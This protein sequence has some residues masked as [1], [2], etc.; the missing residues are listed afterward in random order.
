[1]KERELFNLFNDNPNLITHCPVCNLR[2]NPLEA[3]VLQE[4]EGGHLVYIKCR[5]CQG[6]IL[7]VISANALGISSVGLIT[8][9]SGDDVMKFKQA[10]PISFDDVIAGHQFLKK[11]KALIDYLNYD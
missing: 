9:L 2:F 1:M 5:Q 10:E 6:S 8:D 4:G 7:A 3:K 11:E